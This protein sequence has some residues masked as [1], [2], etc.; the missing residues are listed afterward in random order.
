VEEEGEAKQ[1]RAVAA[2]ASFLAHTRRKKQDHERNEQESSG[3]LKE[4]KV[5]DDIPETFQIEIK[6]FTP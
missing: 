5:R 4:F 3:I 2:P 1:A 6:Y